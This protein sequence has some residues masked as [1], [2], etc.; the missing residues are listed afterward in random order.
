MAPFKQTEV[1]HWSL[2][3]CVGMVE[4]QEGHLRPSPALGAGKQSRKEG[5]RY[6]F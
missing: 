4:T 6:G 5:R 2:E 1:C 3:T